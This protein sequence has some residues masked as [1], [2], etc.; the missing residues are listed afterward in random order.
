VLGHYAR[1]IAIF[2]SEFELLLRT[3]IEDISRKSPLLGEAVARVRSGR[4]IRQQGYDG[5][6]GIIRTFAEGELPR[7]TRQMEL[8]SS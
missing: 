8:F 2:G 6:F 7:Q 4:V 1:A 3:P 5:K